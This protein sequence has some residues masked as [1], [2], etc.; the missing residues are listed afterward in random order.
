MTRRAWLR[1]LAVLAGLALVSRAEAASDAVDLAL[2]MAVDVSESVDGDEYVLQHEGIA[3]AIEDPLLVRAIAAGKHGAIEVAVL[4]WSDRDK[5]VITVDWTRVGDQAS[6]ASFAARVRASRRSSN[7]LT[8]IGDALLA[9]HALL[10]RAPAPADRRLIDVSGDGMANI[11]P[12]V[13]AVRDELVAAG[14][15]INGLAILASEPWL[16]TYYNDYVIGGPGAFLLRAEDFSSFANAM[17]NK[18]QGEVSELLPPGARHVAT[19]R[20]P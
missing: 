16:E 8:A 9:A 20:P 5:Q 4:E 6:A 19:A 2:V 7:G 14:I 3:R 11:G 10:D 12:P 13:Q 17:Q 15:T 1:S 18:L